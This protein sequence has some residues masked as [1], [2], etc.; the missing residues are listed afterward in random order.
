MVKRILIVAGLGLA[1]L[2][3]LL[4]YLRHSESRTAAASNTRMTSPQRSVQQQPEQASSESAPQQ[5]VASKISPADQSLPRSEPAAGAGK[6]RVRIPA[7]PGA[8]GYDLPLD[9]MGG[10]FAAAL[11]AEAM[12]PAWAPDM[13]RRINEALRNREGLRDLQSKIVCRSTACGVLFV[14]SPEGDFSEMR[15]S[16][17]E[18]R[19]SVAS[20]LGFAGGGTMSMRTSDGRRYMQMFLTG[21]GG[22]EQHLPIVISPPSPPENVAT[23]SPSGV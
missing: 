14:F 5:T 2:A 16:V 15:N 8:E 21:P 11:D 1:V 22:R 13:E 12:D 18:F 10:Q 19:E 20:E 9:S 17:K 7:L 6:R 23:G 3:T 4:G